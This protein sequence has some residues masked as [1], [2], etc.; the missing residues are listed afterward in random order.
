MH[1]ITESCCNDGSC[2]A[3]CPVNCI[4]P[5]PDE[6][7]WVGAEMLYIDPD[8]CIDCGACVDVCPVNAIVADYDLSEGNQIYTDVNAAWYQDSNHGDY[9]KEPV[10]KVAP[11]RHWPADMPLR[12]AV[13]GSGAAGCYVVQELLEQPDIDVQINVFD[14]IPAPGGLVRYGVA[15]DHP[16]TKAIQNRFAL[17]L[18]RREVSL[19]LNAEIGTDLSH[20]DL[21]ATHHAV[22]YT[23]GAPDSATL[24][25]PGEKLHGSYCAPPFVGWYNGHPEF[26]D[27]HFD[28]SAQRAVIVGNGNV[29]IDIARI[30]TTDVALLRKTDIASHAL[31]QLAESNVREVVVLGRRGPLQAKFTIPALIGLSSTPNVN[32]R[33]RAEE[34]QE[35]PRSR[36]AALENGAH[37]DDLKLDLLRRS[38]KARSEA[39]RVIELR[40]LASPV[41]MLGDNHVTGLQIR[42]NELSG[43]DGALQ[44]RSPDVVETIEC[45]LVIRSVGYRGR[46]L[47][48]VPFDDRAGVIPNKGGRVIDP[49]DNS[50]S[51]CGVYTAGWAKRGPTGG[52]G[53]NRWCAAQTVTA[54]IDDYVAGRLARP[55][56]DTA[57][58]STLLANGNAIDGD[59]WRAIDA[60]ERAAGR[61]RNAPRDK[62]CNVVEMLKIAAGESARTS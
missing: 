8:T 19:Y 6:P 24:S 27:H 46:K 16:Q 59:G 34:L 32:V 37:M 39:D 9:S 10:R 35:P 3:V 52:I 57:E 62:V 47:A 23:V 21:A 5:T 18:R 14:R 12:V 55:A 36:P 40:F 53:T 33:V 56:R 42:H 61:A 26:A 45:G 1:V 48:G 11:I 60:Y 20:D 51:M 30:L 49:D 50:R 29:A 44:P 54:L 58:L 13:V 25:I 43:D 31:Q 7:G 2:V 17:T 41:Q 15:P 28:L 22:V 38:A 4:H